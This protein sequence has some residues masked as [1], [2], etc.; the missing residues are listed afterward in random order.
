[1][2][3]FNF[4]A[5]GGPFP[6]VCFSCGNNK[7]LYDLGKDQQNGTSYLLCTRCISE[8]A[9][10]TGYISREPAMKEYDHLKQHNTELD[11]QLKA[12]PTLVEGLINGI[13]SSVSDFVL[14]VSSSSDS[15]SDSPVQDGAKA[16]RKPSGARKTEDSN[17]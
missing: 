12:V 5:N 8:I 7:E 10:F 6:G 16:S 13:R 9:S 1:M 11:A 4:F 17:D 15:G 3:Q 2:R 14:A